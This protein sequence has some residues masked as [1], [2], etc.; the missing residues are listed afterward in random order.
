M[1]SPMGGMKA[2]DWTRSSIV[3]MGWVSNEGTE[4]KGE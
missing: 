2:V 3:E 4:M 1:L